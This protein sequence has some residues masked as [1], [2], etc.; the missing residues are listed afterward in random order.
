M[1]TQVDE[2]YIAWLERS[3]FT[4]VDILNTFK[5]YYPSS[6][7]LMPDQPDPNWELPITDDT[8]AIMFLVGT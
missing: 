8:K 7:L 4:L 6:Y 2:A 5:Q 1:A 3:Q